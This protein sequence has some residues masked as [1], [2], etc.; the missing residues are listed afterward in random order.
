M[1]NKRYQRKPERRTSPPRRPRPKT[2]TARPGTHNH[3]V[4]GNIVYIHQTNSK[5]YRISLR[6]I[7]SVLLVLVAAIGVVLSSAQTSN[8][9][10]QI[11][12]ARRELAEK[13]YEIITLR[14]QLEDR[15]TLLEIEQIASAR[16]G[17]TQP[18]PSQIINIYVPRQSY[19]VLNTD[20]HLIPVQNY[21]WQEITSFVTGLVNHIFRA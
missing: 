15:Y 5:G 10:A 21:F 6:M 19:V 4:K 13:Q 18:D 16:L 3:S 8:T 1:D 12:A 7:F 2:G 20:E 17:M 11:A 9:R 14:A